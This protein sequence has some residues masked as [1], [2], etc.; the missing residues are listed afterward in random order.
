M[1]AVLCGVTAD[2]QAVPGRTI[3][4][5]DSEGVKTCQPPPACMS[6][7]TGGQ[8]CAEDH[9]CITL[10]KDISLSD[11]AYILTYPQI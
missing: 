5:E 10:G 3:C 8:F 2:C 6:E 4:K 7:C 11:D 9:S 1:I